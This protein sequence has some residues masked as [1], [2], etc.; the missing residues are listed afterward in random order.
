MS[1]VTGVPPSRGL[2]PL[3]GLRL[4]LALVWI[5]AVTGVYLAAREFGQA[6]VP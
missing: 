6:L 2:E 3:R 4:A 1:G 5:A